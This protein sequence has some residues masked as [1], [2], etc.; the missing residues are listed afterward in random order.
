MLVRA[1][2]QGHINHYQAKKL[3][4]EMCE[5]INKQNKEIKNEFTTTSSKKEE[6]FQQMVGQEPSQE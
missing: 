2:Q 4:N 1:V 5:R 6:T 3:F